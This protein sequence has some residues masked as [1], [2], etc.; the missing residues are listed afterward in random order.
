MYGR[1]AQLVI[2]LKNLCFQNV[3]RHT[4]APPTL[5]WRNLQM[6]LSPVIL[7]CFWENLGQGNHMIIMTSSFSKK[8]RFQNVFPPHGNENPV[9]LNSSRLKSVFE[10]LRFRDGLVWTVGLP[11]GIKLRFQISPNVLWMVPHT[12]VFVPPWLLKRSARRWNAWLKQ[13][14]FE[15]FSRCNV[16]LTWLILTTESRIN[17]LLGSSSN[18]D[19]DADNNA[20]KTNTFR[21]Y[22]SPNL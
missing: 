5:R 16:G 9:F 18:D 13:L 6:Q 19:G 8:L 10:K 20:L 12:N 11:V 2:V 17:L 4:Q 21:F 15:C 7:D 1:K 3:S 22:C 14:W